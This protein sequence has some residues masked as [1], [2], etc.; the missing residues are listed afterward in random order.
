MVRSA[1]LIIAYVN[2]SFGGA[3]KSYKY[4]L[5]RNKKIVNYGKLK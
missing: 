1:D 3:Y 4:A 5:R 2:N